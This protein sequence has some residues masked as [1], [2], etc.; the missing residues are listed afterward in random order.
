MNS[1]N[2]PFWNDP[3]PVGQLSRYNGR[4]AAGTRKLVVTDQRAGNTGTLNSWSLVVTPVLY[5]C[6][7]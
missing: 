3:D 6:G 7:P 5:A 1:L 4:S 2:P